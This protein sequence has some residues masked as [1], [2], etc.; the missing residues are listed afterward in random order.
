MTHHKAP[1]APSLTSLQK[2]RYLVRAALGPADMAAVFALRSRCFGAAGGAEDAFDATSLHVLVIAQD[3]DTVVGSFRMSVLAGAQINSSYAAL[4]YDLTA[5]AQDAGRAL[6]LGRFC[7]HPDHA[8][9]DI[10]RIAWAA[11]T[12]YVD[13]SG[14]EMLLGCASFEGTD[15]APYLDAFALLKARH[16]GPSPRA[17]QVKADEVYRYAARLRR[18]VD[19][20]KAN[21]ATPPLLRTYLL[22][23]GWVSDHAVVDRVMGTLHVF[24]CLE[25]G[26]IPEA[27]KKLLRAL[28]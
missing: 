16:I 15:A 8:D 9:P 25:I 6:E 27:R 17:P 7:V 4:Y 10:L 12:A 1:S 14:I 18:K 28:V 5:L 11:L 26:A 2:G 19:L 13:E 21:A 22:M 20:K 3:T 23:G 24:T